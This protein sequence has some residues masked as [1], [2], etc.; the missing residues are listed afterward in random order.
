LCPK[1]GFSFRIT[2]FTSIIIEGMN[3]KYVSLLF[4]SMFFFSALAEA[5][6]FDDYS[7]KEAA[8][9]ITYS[10]PT[11]NNTTRSANR[12]RS[13]A[14]APAKSAAKPA[15]SATTGKYNCKRPINYRSTCVNGWSDETCS[16][17][18][19]AAPNNQ[20]GAPQGNQAVQQAMQKCQEKLVA[21]RNDCDQHQDTGVQ[22]AEGDIKN[23]AAN[24]GRMGFSACTALGKGIAGANGALAVFSGM[25]SGSK[26]DCTSACTVALSGAKATN[27]VNDIMAAQENLQGCKALDAKIQQ[28]AQQI[29][30]VAA[31][32]SGAQDCSKDTTT[33]GLY[34]FCK[35]NPSAVGCSTEATDCT[36]PSIAAS[37]PICICKDNPSAAT[38]GGANLKAGGGFDNFDSASLG[39]AAPGSTGTLDSSGILGDD[40]WAGDPNAK[41]DNTRAEDVGGSK[42]GRPLDEGGGGRG[43][44]GKDGGGGP[45]GPGTGVAVNAGFRG[46]GG[47]GGSFGGG[48][49]E[50]TWVAEGQPAPGAAANGNP[51]LRNFLPGGKYDP[52]TRGLAGLSGPDGI[53]GP[54]TDIWKKIQNRYQVKQSSL[55]P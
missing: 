1:G 12:S 21:A 46:G 29:Q 47:G 10:R 20:Q 32:V 4:L 52:K 22:T 55:M 33:D 44:G 27:S 36:N 7:L 42:G 45:G 24:M 23:I 26:K 9:D 17:V 49:A 51:D 15:S 2:A 41:S 13:P 54:H 8:S 48:G 35:N 18:G 37:S 34:D 43:G 5:E 39:G 11:N 14:K 31:T 16:C 28:A 3:K 38:C 25:C 50:G 6:D 30:S 19:S 40:D 53:T